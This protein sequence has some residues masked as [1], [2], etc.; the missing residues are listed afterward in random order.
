MIAKQVI[1]L[2]PHI[3]SNRVREYNLP[4]D[5]WFTKRPKKYRH[6]KGFISENTWM[7]ED[8]NDNQSIT[9]NITL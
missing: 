2:P 7:E 8:L 5:R 4:L 9:M 6:Q 3:W 1:Y